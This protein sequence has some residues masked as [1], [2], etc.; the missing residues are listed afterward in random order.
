[1]PPE[2]VREWRRVFGDRRGIELVDPRAARQAMG[3]LAWFPTRYALNDETY[4]EVMDC[5]AAT[6]ALR[7]CDQ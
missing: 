7:R 6:G 3:V 4:I 5:L 1:M 2:L